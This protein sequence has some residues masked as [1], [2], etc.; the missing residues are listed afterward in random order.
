MRKA[1]DWKPDKRRSCRGRRVSVCVNCKVVREDT[2]CR[3]RCV[4][5]WVNGKRTTRV[6]KCVEV[7]ES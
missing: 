7:D 2:S 1:H 5:Y 6:P 4:E 3:G